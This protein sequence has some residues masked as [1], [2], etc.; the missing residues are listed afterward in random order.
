MKKLEMILKRNKYSIFK[1]K[2]NIC[3]LFYNN[4]EKIT[5]QRK[6]RFL[7]ELIRGYEVYY[8]MIENELVAYSVVSKGGGRYSFATEKDIVVGPYFVDEK[9]RG[10]GY[11]EI[12][13]GEILA[14]C[15][16][17]NAYDWIKKDNLPS[18][19]CSFKVGFVVVDTA[20]ILKPFRQ[21]VR[22]D[23]GNGEYYILKYSK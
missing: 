6:I 22:R 8:L 11:S 7:M 12:L 10:K 17:E 13:I 23:N 1:Y 20:D 14:F 2:P 9:F 16:Y 19:K 15:K 21:I 18:L 3:N 4:M 5:V